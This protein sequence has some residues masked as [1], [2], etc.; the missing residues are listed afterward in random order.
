MMEWKFDITAL[1][2]LLLISIPAFLLFSE[3]FIAPKHQA[4]EPPLVPQQIPYLG[5]VAGLFL[6]GMKYFEFTR[7]VM[8][9]QYTKYER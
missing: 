8:V 3:L 5:H 7:Y 1:I 4:Q 9:S 6:H 2:V